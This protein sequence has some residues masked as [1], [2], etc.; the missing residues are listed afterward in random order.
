MTII[1]DKLGLT[2]CLGYKKLL[3]ST[4]KGRGNGD[5]PFG[6]LAP[7]IDFKIYYFFLKALARSGKSF[8]PVAVEIT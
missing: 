1:E 5:V 4:Y 6:L 8:Y 7:I 3:I 2:E